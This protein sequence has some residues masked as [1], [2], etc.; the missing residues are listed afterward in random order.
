MLLQQYMFVLR[1]APVVRA[2]VNTCQNLVLGIP[3]DAMLTP[4][5]WCPSP[6]LKKIMQYPHMVGKKKSNLHP[7]IVG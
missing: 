2:M 4:T 1:E 3:F 7:M 6:F 5:N